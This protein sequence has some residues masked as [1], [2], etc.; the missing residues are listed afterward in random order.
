MVVPTPPWQRPTRTLADR[1]PLSRQR[2]V[3]KALALLAKEGLDAVSMR[4]VAQALATGPASL[5]AH[6]R[7]KEEL[8]QLMLDQLIGAV[9]VPEPDVALAVPLTEGGGAERFE[10]GLDVLVAGLVAV[11][12]PLNGGW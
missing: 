4:R 10:F 6:L 11:S 12:D 7:N 1:P 3:D 2:I 8:D 5:Y 9:T